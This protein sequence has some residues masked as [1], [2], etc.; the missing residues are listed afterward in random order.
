[1]T[2]VNVNMYSDIMEVPYM[3]SIS[4]L[5]EMDRELFGSSSSSSES[6]EE[7][8]FPT[9]PLI[10]KTPSL[11]FITERTNSSSCSDVSTFR[12]ETTTERTNSSSCSDV[13]TIRQETTPPT[14]NRQ[15]TIRPPLESYNNSVRRMLFFCTPPSP[16]PNH[17][18]RKRKRSPN[19]SPSPKPNHDNRKR[20]RF[21]VNLLN[22]VD[23]VEKKM[24]MLC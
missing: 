14:I 4:D 6:E 16:K 9:T 20:K 10:L 3:L 21:N 13:S 19:V 5:E 8:E 12:Q 17:N 24:K 22:Y 23:E 18:N 15:Q 2:P 11:E 7:Q 1:M